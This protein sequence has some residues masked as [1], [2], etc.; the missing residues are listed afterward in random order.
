MRE[1]I[2][3]A[4]RGEFTY[5]D[6]KIKLSITEITISVNAGEI[7]RGEFVVSNDQEEDMRGVVH[8]DSHFLQFQTEFF[9]GKQ[10]AISYQF[11][12]TSLQPGEK[13]T[14]CIRVIS[15]CGTKKLLFEA[16]V[17]VP[18]CE[19][20]TGKIRDLFH[21]TNL[22]KE[23][24]DEAAALFRNKHFEDIFLY[25]DNVNI[26]LYEGLAKGSAKGLAMEEFLIA[27]HKKVGIHITADKTHFLYEDCTQNFQ[28]KIVLT[29]DNWGY[30]EYKV[31]SDSDFVIPQNKRIWTD[32]FIG[33]VYTLYFTINV[34][35][36][37]PGKNYARM[38]VESVGQKT[39]ILIEANKA[40][41]THKAVEQKRIRQKQLLKIIQFYMEFCMGHLEQDVYLSE[42]E[43]VIR[44]MEQDGMT[45]VTQLY[46]THFGIMEHNEQLVQ[47]SFSFLET[48]E[49]KLQK[50]P[51]LYGAYLYLK[52]IW[53]DEEEVVEE[54][55]AKI[56]DLYQKNASDWRYL[57]FLLFL[58]EEYRSEHKKYEDILKQLDHGCHSPVLY[59]EICS[60]LNDDPSLLLELSEG[61]C[62]AIHW[63]SK[64]GFVEEAV[65]TRFC[66]LAGKM[67]YFSKVVL[68]DVC[69]FYEQYQDDELLA[70]VCKILMKGQM[71]TKEA[72]YWYD[73]GVEH[74]LKLTD[75]YEYYM[76]SIDESQE[77]RLQDS[78][79]IYFLYDNHLTVMKKAMLYAYV[80]RN[81]ENMT[82]TYEAY[83]PVMEEY[84]YR[85][86]AEGRINANLAVLYEEFI[87]EDA[88]N[89][90]TAKELANVMFSYELTCEN[91]K[92]IGVYVKHRELEGEI[93]VPL[94]KGKA[95]VQLFT[96]NYQI[97]LADQLD[98]RYALSIDYTLQRF[99]NLDFLAGSCYEKGCRDFRLILYLYDKAERMNQIGKDV[100][101]V[102]KEVL[103][104][105]KLSRHYYKKA[106]CSLVRYY[107][108]NFESELLDEAL[109]EL[110]WDMVNVS[111]RK[112]FFEYCAV[113]RYFDKAMDG[114]YRYGFHKIDGKRLLKIA[115]DSFLQSMEKEDTELLKIAWYILETGH[116]DENML[117]YLCRYYN[118]NISSMVQIWKYAKGF[119]I[120][121][122]DFSERILGQ[123]I[124][125]GEMSP[126]AYEV[127]YSYYPLERDKQLV[128][129]FLKFI[130][131]HYLIHSWVIPTE[132]FDY[133]YKEVQ[134][135]DNMF[136]LI[137][138]LKDLSKKKNLTPEEKQFVE[139]HINRLYEKKMIFPFYREFDGVASLPIHLLDQCYIDYITDPAYEVRIHYMISSGYEKG[140]Y[141]TETMRD[142]FYGQR[143]KEFVLFQD[144][145]LQYYI[146]EVR[147]EGEV[148]TKSASV[149]FDESM[150]NER[151]SSRYH[152]LNLMMI[153][154]EM[155]EENTLIDM[156]KEYVETKESV[157]RLF[158]PL[159]K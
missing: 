122:T 149:R 95:V 22:A 69:R 133:F 57:W 45:I 150:D 76:Y 115:S 1:K 16:L 73:L 46:R 53:C 88:L 113:R 134:M 101:A 54:Y 26:A 34:D 103:G 112:Q 131:Y 144:E 44:Q 127:F 23:K 40:G 111:E 33:N 97:F 126:D 39:E 17:G 109:E 72:F 99:L 66:Y 84:T 80:V 85:Q 41:Q 75:L 121:T 159:D 8:T 117:R 15:D 155:N 158:K 116:F 153:A 11:D 59:L 110:D 118:G 3:K 48:Q 2:N 68:G 10:N 42:A 92:I 14:G 74:N 65:A 107:Y 51:L 29:K 90:K 151:R 132:M 100:M 52:G 128:W 49:E 9:H 147:P 19:V 67:R 135:Q 108:D 50:E 18:S 86:L 125:T 91:E 56:R 138:S 77:M 12:A 79:L 61:V 148:I 94:V 43:N 98:N 70:A 36:M 71:T 63:G 32:A 114:I 142:V 154:Q 58:S 96:E 60:I 146:S 82:E 152:M 35:K 64:Q 87:K 136:C 4:A 6:P 24:P 119:S 81:K 38:T 120:D 143:V 55:V 5:S 13:I 157:N 130:A 140:E 20:S 156:M 21:F 124:F 93:F 129:A 145:M 47:S 25:H 102:R 28:D 141:V 105:E 27:I 83:L 106:F 78:T 37:L 7:V 139:Y 89:E 62:N 104:I 123:I 30:A 137:A 31:T